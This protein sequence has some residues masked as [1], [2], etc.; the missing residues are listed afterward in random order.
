MKIM[1]C[2]L[3][4]TLLTS[5]TPRPADDDVD[6]VWMGYYRSDLSKEKLIVKF[7]SQTKMEFFT[8]G[9]DDRTSSEGSYRIQGDSVSISYKMPSGEQIT[10]QGQFNRRKNFVNGIWK[11]KNQSSGS[12]YLEKQQLQE[13]FAQP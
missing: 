5:F 11:G 10:M 9:V 13:F 8:G 12:F 2:L 4:G 1:M 3:A 7:D 6:G